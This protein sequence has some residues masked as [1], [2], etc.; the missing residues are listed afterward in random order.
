M[1]TV[2]ALIK[3]HLSDQEND[4]ARLQA[5]RRDAHGLVRSAYAREARNFRRVQHVG[6]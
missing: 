6:Q 4:E 5:A 3:S 1:L 2:F